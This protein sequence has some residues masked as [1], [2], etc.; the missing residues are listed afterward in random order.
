MSEVTLDQFIKSRIERIREMV[1]SNEI[2]DLDDMLWLMDNDP[3]LYREYKR[4][5]G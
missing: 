5:M 4:R 3:D 1:Y 2:L